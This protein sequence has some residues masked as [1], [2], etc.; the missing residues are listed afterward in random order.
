MK[1]NKQLF[2]GT[3]FLPGAVLK[4]SDF[5]ESDQVEIHALKNTVIVMKHQMNAMELIQ[6]MDSLNQLFLSLSCHLA[7]TCGTCSGCEGE[8]PFGDFE[9][10]KIELDDDLRKEAGIPTDAKLSLYVDEEDHTIIVCEAGYDHDLRD[11][12]PYLLE[13]MAFSGICLGELEERLMVGDIIYGGST[14][15]RKEC[16]DE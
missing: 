7:K 8:C 4:I 5:E 6:A 10:D 12:P 16:E 2:N 14:R 15:S 3:I 11:I 9:Y 13:M 1:F